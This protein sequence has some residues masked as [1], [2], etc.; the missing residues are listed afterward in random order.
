MNEFLIPMLII[1]LLILING[2]FVAAEFAIV[3]A[4]Y[5]RIARWAAEGKAGAARVLPWLKEPAK[6]NRYIGTAQVGITIAS[7][8]L[9][10]Y[11]EETIT[12]WLTYPLEHYLNLDA[13]AA[14]SIA[15]IGGVAILTY[16][17]VV[18]GEMIAKSIAIQS[19]DTSLLKLSGF[20][21]ITQRL[22]TPFVISLNAMA[23]AITRAVGIPPADTQDRLLSAEELEYIVEE[24]ASKGL[25]DSTERVYVEN[26]FDLHE[27]LTGQVMTPRN[28][29]VGISVTTSSEELLNIVCQEPHSRYPVFEDDL[30]HV[31]GVLHVKSLARQ[32]VNNPRPF[33]VSDLMRQ[34]LFVPEGVKVGDVLRMMRQKHEHLAIVVDEF[35]GIAGLLTME[36][37]IEEVVGEIQDEYDTE[38]PPIRKINDQVI[39]VRGDLLLDELNQHYA[40]DLDAEQADTIGGLIMESLARMPRAGDD[41]ALGNIRIQVLEIDGFAVKKARIQL[42]NSPA[43]D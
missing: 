1:G 32:L 9:G 12:H 33:T 38:M 27:R 4:P 13:G 40:L 15:L 20:M 25:L 11:G 10:M 41:L 28:R 39:D 22:F 14:H 19:S 42:P 24:S 6:R 35:G 17:H 36:D 37:I 2:L 34:P 23:D 7:L 18:F 3:V 21:A 16:L 26:I 29:L 8:G 30:D 43:S 5:S 31:V